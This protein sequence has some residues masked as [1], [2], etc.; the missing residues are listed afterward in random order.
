MGFLLDRGNAPN[1][2]IIYVS[3]KEAMNLNEFVKGLKALFFV[4]PA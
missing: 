1:C 4:I 2:I 3:K